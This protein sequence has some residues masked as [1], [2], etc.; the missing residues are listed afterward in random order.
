MGIHDRN[1]LKGMIVKSCGYYVMD[2]AT[3]HKMINVAQSS[4]KFNL[5][6]SGQGAN[7]PI[8]KLRMVLCDCE[9]VGAVIS[10]ISIDSSLTAHSLK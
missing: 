6:G 7:W 9:E 3:A 5:C 8:L 10:I 2:G 1:N 4:G